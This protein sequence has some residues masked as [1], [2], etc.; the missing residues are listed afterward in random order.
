[1]G[2]FGDLFKGIFGSTQDTQTQQS[3]TSNT[4]T[5][6]NAVNDPRLQALFNQM[7]GGIYSGGTGVNAWQ[8]NAA[9]QLQGAGQFAMPAFNAAG[10]VAQNGITTA[11]IMK[12]QSPYTQ[13]VVDAT[14]RQF[15]VNNARSLAGQQASAAKVGALTGTQRGV[16]RSIME[17]NLTAQQAPIIAGQ[18]QQGYQNA[19]DTAA[20]SAGLQTQ[21]AGTTGSI[22]G[23]YTG[24]GN[25]AYG[26]GQGISDTTRNYAMLPYQQQ[27][28]FLPSFQ[29]AYG[30]SSNTN[31]TGTTNSSTTKTDSPFDVGMDLLGGA[32]SFGLFSDERVKHDIKPVGKTFDG[33]P[34]YTF[35]YNGDES[36]RTHMGLMAQDVEQEKPGAVGSFQGVKTVDYDKATRASGGSVSGSKHKEFHEKVTDAFKAISEMK[37]SMGGGVMPRADGGFVPEIGNDPGVNYD[38]S[39]TPVVNRAPQTSGFQDWLKGRSDARAQN[40]GQGSD[41]SGAIASNEKMMSSFMSSMTPRADGGYIP[42][43]HRDG[44]PV[45][46]N[47]GF[48]DFGT[49]DGPMPSYAGMR[50]VER[51]PVIGHPYKAPAEEPAPESGGFF[52]GLSS[53]LPSVK[54][55]GVI[56]GDRI[57]PDQSIG[58]VI[59]G[60]G[61]GR[62]RDSVLALSNNRFKELEAEREAGRLL[63]NYQ[64]KPTMDAQR[65]GLE[66]SIALGEIDGNPTLA[67]QRFGHERDTAIGVARDENGRVYDTVEGRRQA[68]AERTA[69]MPVYKDN[70]GN[71]D[72]FGRPIPGWVNPSNAPPE[73][74]GPSTGYR[75]PLSPPSPLPNAAATPPT[76][77]SSAAVPSGTPGS[78]EQNPVYVPNIAAETDLIKTSPGTYYRTWDNKVKRTPDDPSDPSRSTSPSPQQRVAQGPATPSAPGGNPFDY[79]NDPG[80][81]PGAA[82]R[83]P[84]AAQPQPTATFGTPT[85]TP[86]VT[87]VGTAT[88]NMDT[89]ATGASALNQLPPIM[90]TKVLQALDGRIAPPTGL[91]LKDPQQ[92]FILTAAQMVDPSFDMNK[93]ALRH[94]MHQDYSPGGKIGNNLASASMSV[95]H[96][97]DLM[98]AAEKLDNSNLPLSTLTRSWITNPIARNVSTDYATRV[99]DFDIKKKLAMEE[100][101]K[102]LRGS[103]AGNL[104]QHEELM[105][106]MNAAKT[107]AE[108]K[109]TVK[110]AINLIAGK[111]EPYAAAYNQVFNTQRS[112]AEFLSPE[113]KKHWEA[114]AGDKRELQ[115]KKDIGQMS[116]EELKG[117]PR[118]QMSPEQLRSASQRLQDLSRGP[119][120]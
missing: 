55:E 119:R 118:D 72:A 90:Q 68:E 101:G 102:F 33:M 71:Y 66:R 32:M 69:R 49:D 116:I 6:N 82:P 59:S 84:P 61:R 15:D 74:A 10:N 43:G 25:A 26:A 81:A 50:N 120:P 52:S 39:W 111:M 99:A 36:G 75:T 107:D 93:W 88:S 63:G 23:A 51:S 31:S 85:P 35:K 115:L 28:T 8:T 3:G 64:G 62:Y 83:Q 113:A 117:L 58:A 44:N 114:I 76:G 104:T 4:T 112:T 22:L 29:N 60:M 42:Q 91:A 65:L 105:S 87:P 5:Q 7:F 77:P 47:E 108:L 20:K 38:S 97:Y 73:A 94:K 48:V 53:F 2:G 100:L 78:S 21:A 16:G 45:W 79:D 13:Q 9:D 54:R 37:R 106:T 40:K 110:A 98:K 80:V 24:A 89:T 11:D 67:R 14:Q 18:Y 34:I 103:G 57:T 30:T 17:G 56:T 95:N 46:S 70:T 92:Q 19:V 86:G 27:A 12:Y 96:L 1:M 41:M 109:T